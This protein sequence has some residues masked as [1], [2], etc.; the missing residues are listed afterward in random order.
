MRQCQIWIN[1]QLTL[2]LWSPHYYRHLATADKSQPLEKHIQKWLKYIPSIT[3]SC[4]C[5][6]ADSFLPPS[7]TFHLFFLLLLNRHLFTLS[8]IMTSILWTNIMKKGNKETILQ[9][10]VNIWNFLLTARSF[11][12]LWKLYFIC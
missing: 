4:Y 1:L 7:M 3:D 11:S 5:N 6:N 9:L 2:A 10:G 8:K 12:G